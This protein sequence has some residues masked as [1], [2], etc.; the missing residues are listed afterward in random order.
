[1]ASNSPRRSGDSSPSSP[2]LPYP[3]S[4]TSR[5]AANGPG[6][7]PSLRGAPRF[8]RRT[9][10]RRLMR[11]PSVAVRDSAAEHLEERQT[12][13]AY[14]KPLVVLDVPSSRACWEVTC[15][16]AFAQ[17]LVSEGDGQRRRR[18]PRRRRRWARPDH[19]D[20]WCNG[21]GAALLWGKLSASL[22]LSLQTLQTVLAVHQLS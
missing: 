17:D 16:C 10:S 21:G 18:L 7:L 5:A 14:S 4:P 12:D 22:S 15:C 20:R 1:M 2:L 11:E 9:G 13:W 8:L 3:T 6:R 19:S